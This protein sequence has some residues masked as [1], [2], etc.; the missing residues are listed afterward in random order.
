MTSVEVTTGSRLHFGLICAE[1][2]SD[3]RFGG[4][5]LMLREP[6]WRLS[7]RPAS[8]FDCESESDEVRERVERLMP[9]IRVRFGHAN[10][11]VAVRDELPLHRGLGAGTQFS[12]AVAT[13]ALISAGE[14]RPACSLEL[15]THLQRVRRSAIGA[16]GFD[17][18][19]F[20]VDSGQ[21]P[22]GQTRNLQR[23]D[24]PEEWR[25]VLVHPDGESGISGTHEESVFQQEHWMPPSL[26]E[27][28]VQLAKRDILPAIHNANFENFRQAIGQYGTNAGEFFASQQGGIFSSSIIR[29]ITESTEFG[30]LRPVQSS[31]GPN[32]AIFA[33]SLEHAKQ[34][35][36]RLQA[37]EFSRALSCR[38]VE[39]MNLGASVRTIAPETPD[40]VAR[41]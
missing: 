39:P 35:V 17:R 2:G 11:H 34:V 25:I 27:A 23:Y 15:A 7:L 9:T 30:D 19:G 31:W 8:D 29:G 41:G 14:S 10:L 38:I 28:Q 32:V 3:Y 6:A 22:T 21:S 1:P 5:G 12:L 18:G 36:A 13:A 4:I 16:F 40:H 37:S 26:V 24:F 33:Q 20:I